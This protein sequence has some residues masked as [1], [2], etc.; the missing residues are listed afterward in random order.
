MNAFV[1]AGLIG[2]A[3]LAVA[4]WVEIRERRTAP[5]DGDYRN[6]RR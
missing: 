1:T 2:I 4:V 6:S 3:L 5:G